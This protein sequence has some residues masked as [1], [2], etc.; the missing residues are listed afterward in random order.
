MSP[1]SLTPHPHGILP[2]CPM[3]HHPVPRMCGEPLCPPSWQKRAFSKSCAIPNVFP[4]LF[5]FLLVTP[6]SPCPSPLVPRLWSQCRSW[7]TLRS[8]PSLSV[9]HPYGCFQGSL[10]TVISAWR[11][12]RVGWNGGG[13]D[14]GLPYSTLAH[15]FSSDQ[16][17]PSGSTGFQ[18][19]QGDPGPGCW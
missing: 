11:L 15:G 18:P 10:S 17:S 5:C 6:Y 13:E 9:P 12:G 8:L 7:F 4:L 16:V 1:G 14:Q 2:I 3:G 19:L